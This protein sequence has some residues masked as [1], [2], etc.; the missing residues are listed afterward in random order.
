[1]KV[2]D[3]KTNGSFGLKIVIPILLAIFVYTGMANCQPIPNIPAKGTDMHQWVEQHFAKGRIP[4]FSFV[5][6]GKSSDNF[7]RNW[8]YS[9][10]RMK[11]TDPNAEESVYTYSD[12]QS[13]LVVKCFVTCFKDFQAVEWVLKFSNTSGKNT[14]LIERA[15]VINQSFV[16]EEKGT[17]VLHHA[18]GS[19]AERTD[20]QPI[21]EKMEIGKSTYMTPVG[22]RS[23]DNTAFPFFNIGI[24]GQQGI[25]VAVGWTGKWYADVRQLD[26]KTVSLKSG[27]EKMQVKLYPKE[28]IR[29][30][31]ICLLFWKGDDR[32]IG[33]NQFRQFV[34]AHHTRKIN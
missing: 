31:K 30:P 28:E 1:M 34:L 8:Q 3:R 7:I 13:G 23:S 6:G 2:I 20:F 26:E 25:M 11:S 16:S 27:M 32:M 29:T 5:Y 24:P 19:N 9:A 15:A 17:F 22:G 4:P 12:K 21:D 14:P 33:H 10:E 18:K